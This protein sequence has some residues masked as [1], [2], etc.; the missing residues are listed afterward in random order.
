[1]EY[2]Q[3]PWKIGAMES[4]MVAIDSS[5]DKEVTGFIDPE[6]ASRILACVNACAGFSATELEQ[7]AKHG[8]F[9][10]QTRYN[11][12]VTKQRNELLAT[13]IAAAS[14]AHH[15]SAVK[16]LLDDALASGKGGAA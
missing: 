5:D 13:V 9:I 1:M 4:G 10:D 2:K 6:D 12:K 11:A 3:T 14:L 15:K 16:A 8:G 7:V